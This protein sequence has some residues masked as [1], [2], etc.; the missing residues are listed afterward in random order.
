MINIYAARRRAQKKV[1]L[2]AHKSV[3]NQR[4][5]LH[6]SSAVLCGAFAEFLFHSH[7]VE[8]KSFV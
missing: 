4:K 3:E 5:V 1:A 7:F 8:A 2:I 6:K